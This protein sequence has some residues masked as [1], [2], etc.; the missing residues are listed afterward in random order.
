MTASTPTEVAPADGTG[1]TVGGTPDADLADAD[2]PSGSRARWFLTLSLRPV[3]LY[4]ASR[5]GMLL[6]ACATSSTAHQSVS[7]G[8]TSWDSTWYLS[9][10]R[11]GY[12]SHIP[13]GSGNPAQSNLGFFPLLPILIRATHQVTGF[14]IAMSGLITT[15]LLGLA[16]SVAVWWMLRDL[17]GRTGA[18]RG[19]ALVFFSPG[20]LVLS[21]VYTCL[22]Y[23]SP[24][25]RDRQ[26]SRM[27]SS[28]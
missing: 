14:G 4:L 9:I 10:A 1:G 22:L 12:A 28:A 13:P 8:L 11:N 15:F 17:F 21:L 7:R 2:A 23:T 3:L 26:K 19:T 16:A 24:S 5:A 27:P 20:A 25:P 18:D 6:V